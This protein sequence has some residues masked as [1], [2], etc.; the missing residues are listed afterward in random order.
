M[1]GLRPTAARAI[2]AALIVNPIVAPVAQTAAAIP[3]DR[4][5]IGL[6]GWIA[7]KCGLA[8]LGASLDLGTLAASNPQGER[9]L[10]FTVNCNTPFAYSL[11]SESGGLSHETAT[12]GGP[13]LLALLPY[14]AV[15]SIAADDGETLRLAC[16]SGAPG[17]SCAAES[18]ERTAVA[19]DASLVLSWGPVAGRLIAGRYRDALR[20]GLT[21]RN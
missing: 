15:L 1:T 11:A 14:D 19:K 10:R 2:A 4:V 3:S 18:G 20:I 7:P 6:R 8:G 5:E 21:A 9:E 12:A 17:Q 13:G 16:A